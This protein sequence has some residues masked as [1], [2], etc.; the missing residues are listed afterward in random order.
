MFSKSQHDLTPFYTLNLYP[1][2]PCSDVPPI[3]VQPFLGESLTFIYKHLKLNLC[4]GFKFLLANY[5]KRKVAM[6]FLKFNIFLQFGELSIYI[7]SKD[8]MV[9]Y[10]ALVTQMVCL[11]FN[12]QDCYKFG[13]CRHFLTLLVHWLF[14]FLHYLI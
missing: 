7:S 12:N 6:E 5:N 1:I 11:W 10:R 13:R 4:S 14:S 3:W 8:K 9:S 2:I